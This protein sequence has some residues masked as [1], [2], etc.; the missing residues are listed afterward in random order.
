MAWLLHN[1]YLPTLNPTQEL[2]PTTPP[3]PLLP[4]LTCYKDTMKTITRDVTLLPK[5][6]PSLITVLRDL[7]RWI[8]ECKVAANVAVGE[9]GFG[10]EYT[11]NDADFKEIWALESFC[12]GLASKWNACSNLEK[13]RGSFCSIFIQLIEMVFFFN[14]K[15]EHS[16]V[17]HP[18]KASISYWEVLLQHVHSM[19][20]EFPSV[21]C[22][23][24]VSI[25]L[26]PDPDIKDIDQR[27]DPSYDT[28]L[29]CWVKWAVD[30]WG[31]TEPSDLQRET[32]STL[33][34]GIFSLFLSKSDQA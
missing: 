3:R 18:S 15:R 10:S 23:R 31:G 12:D 29:A 7:E 8:A 1:Y 19:H 5:H 9:V 32:L 14:R 17:F 33:M 28:Y 34:K 21:L 27:P 4:I 24:F 22:R 11:I 16:D 6:R 30:T 2:A 13:V 26:S 25:L 20:S